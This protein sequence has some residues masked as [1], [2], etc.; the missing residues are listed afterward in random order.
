M[1]KL[2]KP[3]TIYDIAEIADVSA[4]TVSR[5]L[6][7]SNYPVS[8]KMREKVLKV[9][10]ENEYIP[11]MLGKQLKTNRN[12]MIGV[13]IPTITNPFY[14]SVVLGIEELSRKNDYHVLLSNTMQDPNLEDIYLEAIFE[15]QIKGLVISS[16]STNPQ[17]LQNLVEKGLKVVAIDQKIEVN[18]V[19]Q[20][21][22]DFRR[23]GYIATKYLLEKGHRK[24]S[25]IS[26][27]LDRYS[28]NSIFLGYKDALEEYNIP[29]NDEYVRISETGLSLQ[30]SSYEFENGRKLTKPLLELPDPPTAIFACNDMT[31]LGSINE[32]TSH[33]ISVPEEMS[34]VGFDDIDVAKM[35][36]PSL[37][38]IKQP[39]YEMGKLACQLLID[40]L[41]GGN[42]T[43]TNGTGVALKP[44]LVERGSVYDI[45]NV[46]TNIVK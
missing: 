14:P 23:G 12:M 10:K 39:T 29:L 11:N 42:N 1:N 32:L 13:I 27:P 15:R 20:V 25:Y 3:I 31:A 17:L 8:E 4:A 43:S 26:A 41:D 22:Y 30:D 24:I 21:V 2:K 44:Q 7:N 34:I 33:G 6:S 19:S 18:G 9:A 35:S 38:T 5:V 40:M 45:S 28:R 16:I 36:Q 46:V 37:T